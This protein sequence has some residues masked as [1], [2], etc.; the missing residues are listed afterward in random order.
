M[1]L[2][3]SCFTILFLASACATATP[4]SALATQHSLAG[5][6]LA[7]LSASATVERARIQT[8]LDYSATRVSLAAT[9]GSFFQ[10]TLVAQGTPVEV[11]QTFQAQA[12]QGFATVA[13]PPSLTPDPNVQNTGAN[14]QPTQ[15][16]VT[17]LSA[18]AFTNTPAVDPNTPRLEEIVISSSV[19]NDDCA[20]GVSTTFT[21]ATTEIYVVARAINIVANTPIS[22]EWFLEGQSI[23]TYDFV[24]D[25]DIA[26]ACIWFFITPQA[27]A[28][29]PGNW[30]IQLNLNGTPVGQRVIFTLAES[31]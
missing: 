19:G 11:M 15:V 30:S 20:T 18:P 26:N 7:E 14:T 10:L 22:S 6:Q 17:P 28:F 8:T 27:V 23:V 25:F 4:D 29:T 1:K 3:F 31:Q 9:Q 16:L 24:P 12:F 2:I 5:T 21:T 13:S